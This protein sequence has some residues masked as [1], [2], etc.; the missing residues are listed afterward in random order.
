MNPHH[1]NPWRGLTDRRAT[2]ALKL[3]MC[4]VLA[5]YVGQFIV[6]ILAAVRT[7]IY[8][9]VG[10]I[11]FAYL[12]YPAV[13]RLR[14]RMPLAAAISVVYAVVLAAVAGLVWFVI[15]RVIDEGTMLV[16]RYP[17]LVARVHTAVYDPRDPVTSHLPDWLQHQMA[18]APED[19]AV[20]VRVHGLQNFGHIVV[21]LIGTFAAMATFI[22]IPLLAAYLLLDLENLKR[23]LSALVPEERWRSMLELLSELDGV[24]GGFIRGQL[25][26]ALTVGV[27]ITIAL[28][29]LGVPYPALLGLVAAVGDLVPYVGALMAFVPAF[30]AAFMANGPL[31]AGLVLVAFVVIFQAEG[32]FIAPNIVSKS[33]KLS[34]FVVLLALLVGAELGGIFGMLVAIPIAGVLRVI[35]L[36]IFERKPQTDVPHIPNEAPSTLPK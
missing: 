27:L 31:N 1:R 4:I 25:L 17:E 14:A 10:S 29:F 22:A 5:L 34:P 15:P 20:W 24:I 13:H 33:V 32:H 19:F 26:V 18:R 35:A 2:Y 16:K 11:L 30:L 12:V 7:V 23:G 3:L 9:L 28:A 21:V 36:R 8:I 6:G